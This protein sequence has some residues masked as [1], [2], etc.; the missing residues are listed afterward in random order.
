MMK[1]KVAG[2][3]ASGNIIPEYN[4]TKNTA[5]G[6]A[7][8]NDTPKNGTE[9]EATTIKNA[10]TGNAA[11]IDYR[12]PPS[13][14]NRYPH[15]SVTLCMA[16]SQQDTAGLPWY[17][18]IQYWCLAAD[19]PGFMRGGFDWTL[20]NV[21]REDSWWEERP[22]DARFRF[23]RYWSIQE[24]PKKPAHKCRWVGLVT[25]HSRS[26]EDLSS[27]H[28]SSLRICHLIAAS[29]RYHSSSTSSRPVF[30]YK[31]W[32]AKEYVNCMQEDGEVRLRWLWPM[33]SV[34]VTS[35]ASSVPSSHLE[36][37]F[38]NLGVHVV[39]IG[40]FSGLYITCGV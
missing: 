5:T 1:K 29:A 24:D 18:E 28:L 6:D 39:I 14:K 22:Q 19:L 30:W 40:M 15:I 21:V 7:T 8:T 36:T 38:I 20:R 12:A 17:V 27:L 13:F 2:N 34:A 11:A 35:A 10:A 3:S 37:F 4:T 16:G 23:R 26:I 33:E 32:G 25:L 31:G 9:P